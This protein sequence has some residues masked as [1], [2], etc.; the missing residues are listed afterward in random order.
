MLPKSR[1][2]TL[3]LPI[4]VSA[5]SHINY[6]RVH[7]PLHLRERLCV[8]VCCSINHDHTAESLTTRVCVQT[9]CAFVVHVGSSRQ[10]CVLRGNPSDTNKH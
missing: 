9:T 3:D 5:H 8:C 7:I 1:K 4:K 10:H 6:L 2:K